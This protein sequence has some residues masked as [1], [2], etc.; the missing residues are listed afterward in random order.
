MDARRPRA[1]ALIPLAL[2]AVACIGAGVALAFRTPDPR[3]A[4][5]RP[6]AI[7]YPA[8]D[9]YTRA[10]AELGRKLFFDTRLSDDRTRSCASCHRPGQAWGDNL[11]RSSGRAGIALPFRTPT[12]LDLAWQGRM[13]WDGKFQDIERVA[14]GPIGGKDN[15]NLPEAEAVSRISGDAGY[16]ADFVEAFGDDGVDR[17]RIERALGAYVRL[18]V[19]AP[20]PFDRWVAG[21]RD[22]IGA[23]ARRG[24][25]LFVGKARCASCHT[26]WSMS[27]GSFHDIG[28]ESAGP[29]RGRLFPSSTLLQ[30]AHKTPGLRDVANRA[31]YMHDGSVK[32]LEAVVDLYDK[33]GVARPSRAPEIGPLGLSPG[34]RADLVAFLR[35]LSPDTPRDLVST[36]LPDAP[37]RP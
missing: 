16:R 10:K 14:F 35:S 24:F 27:D 29:G 4:F 2:A 20:S 19:S 21:E 3:L 33:G 37:P 17:P 7:P 18:M 6:A 1:K 30:H 8:S 34:E 15:M 32:T 9:P 26:G 22:A 31:P 36:P 13:G 11:P 28:L 25:T 5:A 12:L 23:D